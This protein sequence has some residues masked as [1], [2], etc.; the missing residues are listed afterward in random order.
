VDLHPSGANLAASRTAAQR[1]DVRPAGLE[2]FAESVLMKRW[3]DLHTCTGFS[4]NAKGPLSQRYKLRMVDWL[5]EQFTPARWDELV[6]E[7]LGFRPKNS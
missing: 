6:A 1:F 4:S 3:M 5:A 7:G 2:P